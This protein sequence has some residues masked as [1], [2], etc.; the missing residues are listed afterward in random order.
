MVK[1][2]KKR[3]ILVVVVVVVVFF[4]F[5]FFRWVFP[6]LPKPIPFIFSVELVQPANLIF[7]TVV[8]MPNDYL[9]STISGYTI[10]KNGSLIARFI[11]LD[12]TC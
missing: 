5:F 8:V 9:L 7:K 4:F 11:L 2:S 12:A 6:V 10:L 3:P 1:E